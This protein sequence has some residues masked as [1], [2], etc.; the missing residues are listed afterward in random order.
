ML[1][2]VLIGQFMALL[3]VFIVNVAAPTVRSDLGASDGALQLVLAGYTIT[4]AV[5]LITGARLGGRHGHGRLFLGGLAVFTA[6]SLACGL[7][8]TSGQ[9]IAFRLVQG[10]GAALMLPQV[11]ALIQR[12]FQGAER[13][14]ALMAF[15]LVVATGAAAGQVVG[16]VLIS[17]DLLGLGWRPVF[18]VNVPIGVALLVAGLRAVPLGRPGGAERARGLDLPGLTLL[19][20][21]VLAFTVPLV[22]GQEEGWPLWCW[23]SLGA[24]ALLVAAFAAYEARLARGGGAP[25]LSPRVLRSPGMPLA[26]TRLFLSMSVNAGVLFTLSLHLQGPE[27]AGGLGHGALRTGLLFIPTAVAFGATS[28]LWRRLPTGWHGHLAPAGFLVSA[29]ALSWLAVTLH[30]G[31]GGP[32][33]LTGPF[34]LNGLGLALAYGPVLTRA[35][36]LVAPEDA[37]DASGV[38]AMVSQL[39]MLVG[40]A[41]FGTLFINR[42]ESTLSTADAMLPT[43]LAIAATALAGALSGTLPRALSRALPRL[44]SR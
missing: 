13:A 35:L 25:L 18:L 17:A 4:Y 24:S 30:A 38:T 16:G 26:A 31:H 9:L 6:A 28:L 15:A 36:A 40:I 14:R 8:A 5:L 21:A 3:D 22:L 11:L 1:A 33:A 32:A 29:A 23:L 43:M 41:A 37:G 20:A 7:A 42:A 12:T 34:L 39:G 44:R 27:A 2:I 10:A 19:T